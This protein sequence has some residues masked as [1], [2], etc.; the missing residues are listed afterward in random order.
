[1]TS[2][3]RL[4]SKQ[5]TCRHT[6][7]IVWNNNSVRVSILSHETELEVDYTWFMHDL[8]PIRILRSHTLCDSI[9]ETTL[10]KVF[11]FVDTQ[12]EDEGQTQVLNPF[13]S[14]H[15]IEYQTSLLFFNC[16]HVLDVVHDILLTWIDMN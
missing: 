2:I 3:G 6:S 9:R 11:S 12:L 1:M 4:L 5:Y 7:H 15:F 14:C 16:H 10:A 8:V 13:L